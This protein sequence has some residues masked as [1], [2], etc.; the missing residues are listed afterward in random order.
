M[1]GRYSFGMVDL[2]LSLSFADSVLVRWFLLRSARFGEPWLR[3]E[4]VMS[5][6]LKSVCQIQGVRPTLFVVFFS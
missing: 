3:P 1:A 2:I 5:C 6:F 4:L